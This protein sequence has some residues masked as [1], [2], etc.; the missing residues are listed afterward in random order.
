MLVGIVII[1]Q[2]VSKCVHSIKTYNSLLSYKNISDVM[3]NDRTI[4]T[5]WM[6]TLGY[7]HPIRIAF[8]G[9]GKV[10]IPIQYITLLG[11]AKLRCVTSLRHNRSC[12]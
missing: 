8:R 9:A 10:C 2:V 6:R 1:A 11:A 12:M 3:R 5:A 7:A 4:R